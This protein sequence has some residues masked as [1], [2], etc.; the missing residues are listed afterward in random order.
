MDYRFTFNCDCFCPGLSLI[1][2]PDFG[3][4]NS[5]TW[6]F[7]CFAGNKIYATNKGI[8]SRCNEVFAL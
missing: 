5:Q 3:I 7:S 1:T 6:A 4:D 2:G 8:E